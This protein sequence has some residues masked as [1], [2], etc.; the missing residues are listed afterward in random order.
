MVRVLSCLKIP[1]VRWQRSLWCCIF[2]MSSISRSSSALADLERSW[3]LTPEQGKKERKKKPIK[4]HVCRY[5]YF[6]N[7]RGKSWPFCVPIIYAGPFSWPACPQKNARGWNEVWIPLNMKV[8]WRSA[9]VRALQQLPECWSVFGVP[10]CAPCRDLH[11]MVCTKAGTSTCKHAHSA[12]RTHARHIEF[13]DECRVVS[14]TQTAPRL[15]SKLVRLSTA[16]CGNIR[17][18]SVLTDLCAA[19]VQTNAASAFIF[20]PLNVIGCTQVEPRGSW[21][22][23]DILITTHVCHLLLLFSLFSIKGILPKLVKDPVVTVF[24]HGLRR[25]LTPTLTLAVTPRCMLIRRTKRSQLRPR[26][27]LRPAW[28]Y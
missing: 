21:T 8:P 1:S 22:F 12:S 17:G 13:E 7:S 16:A 5:V 20:R 15:Q 10:S 28:G 18:E 6:A 9:P 24:F 19:H 26:G 11:T 23:A 25:S 2:T 3:T 4:T 14:D 27:L